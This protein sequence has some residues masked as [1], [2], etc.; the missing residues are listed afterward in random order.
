VAQTT[1]CYSIDG[2]IVGE[3][4]TSRMNYGVDAL[5]SVTASLSGP[6]VQNTYAFKPYGGLLAKTGLGPDASFGWVG[7]EGY[8]NS[9]RSF[10]SIYVRARTYS[11]ETCRWTTADPLLLAVPQRY[12]YASGRVLTSVDPSGLW[13]DLSAYCNDAYP[14]WKPQSYKDVAVTYDMEYGW[15]GPE[16]NPTPFKDPFE[17]TVVSR[18]TAEISAD[19]PP[20]TFGVSRELEVGYKFSCEGDWTTTGAWR[21]RC[22]WTTGYFHLIWGLAHVDRCMGVLEKHH[23]RCLGRLARS[24]VYSKFK[25]SRCVNQWNRDERLAQVTTTT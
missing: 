9:D 6:I 15:S 23:A 18:G 22:T 8:R 25:P 12:A 1:Y 10:A 21:Y 11:T 17:A 14:D 20:F 19:L 2:Q 7:S 24:L 4:G 13:Q 16:S 5:G 3:R